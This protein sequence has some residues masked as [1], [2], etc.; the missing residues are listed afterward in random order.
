MGARPTA[1]K[2][3]R[4][5]PCGFTGNA[6]HWTWCGGKNCTGEP[7]PTP[8]APAAGGGGKLGWWDWA[9]DTAK[10]PIDHEI[11]DARVNLIGVVAALPEGHP[12][13]VELATKVSE[14]EARKVSEVPTT[15]R[16]RLLLA[17]SARL[18]KRKEA[19]D[20]VV[21]AAVVTVQKAT[22]SLQTKMAESETATANHN[23]NTLEIAELTRPVQAAPAPPPPPVVALRA[24]I[25]SVDATQLALHG[26][27]QDKLAEFFL[28]FT[29]LSAALEVA[30]AAPTTAPPQVQQQQQQQQQLQ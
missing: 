25:D 3:W 13:I 2:N 8:T 29:Q 16:L 20:A 1:P 4:C 11:D 28:A 5:P 9:N 17:D 23:A 21:A 15:E 24:A 7:R 12:T 26:L 14:L 10:S 19:A 22:T 18:L 30:K 27:T 6:P